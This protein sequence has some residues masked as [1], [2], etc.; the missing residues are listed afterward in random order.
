MSPIRR[1]RPGRRL[2]IE[3][4]DARHHAAVLADVAV[5]CE[6]VA[7]AHGEH[8]RAAG[9]RV[10]ERRTV[11]LE[12]LGDEQLVAILAAADE[13][14][15]G[16]RQVELLADAQRTLLELEPAPLEPPAHDLHV[17]A[18]GVDRE[19]LGVQLAEHE[20][21]AAASSQYGFASPRLAATR[22]SSSIAV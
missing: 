2:E 1:V 9:D 3:Q 5:A 10:V 13:V 18:V 16:L 12:I 6:L 15:V 14:Q 8:G 11:A 21:H 20:P 4:A 17:A 19:V 7:A 22:C